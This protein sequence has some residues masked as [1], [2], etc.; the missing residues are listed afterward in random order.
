MAGKPLVKLLQKR[1]K[2]LSGPFRDHPDR[3]IGFIADPTS[4]RTSRGESFR[5]PAKTDPLNL[6]M[7]DDFGSNRWHVVRSG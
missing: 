3:S 2:G 4:K 1:V 6:A 5:G 7:E